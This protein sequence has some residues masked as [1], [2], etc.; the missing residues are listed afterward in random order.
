MHDQED[1]HDDGERLVDHVPVVEQLLE[2]APQDQAAMEERLLAGRPR[3]L[4]GASMMTA[5]APQPPGL[6][7]QYPS[8]RGRSISGVE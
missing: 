6:S 2:P 4:A 8:W 5:E 7:V 3:Q 1:V